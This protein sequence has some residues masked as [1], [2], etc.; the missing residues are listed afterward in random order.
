MKVLHL[1]NSNR[2]SGA[3][4]VACQIVNMFRTDQNIEMIYVS[5]DGEIREALRE[6]NVRYVPISKMTIKEV[7]RVIKVEKP[8][9]VYA[10]DMR[11][12]VIAAFS[13]GNIKL[14]SH[15][16]NNAFDSRKMSVKSLAYLVAARKVDHIFWVSEEAFRDYK[17]CEKL[18]SKS[19]VLCNIIDIGQLRNRMSLDQ[20]CYDNDIVY[21]GRLAYPKNPHRL[22]RVINDVISILPETRVTI[23]GTGEL[24][25]EVKVLVKAYNLE[26]NVKFVGFMANPLKI[27]HDSKVMLMTS[28]WEGTPMCALE[29]MALGVPIVSTPTDGLNKLIDHGVTGFVS[30]DDK[31]LVDYLVA[32]ISHKELRKSL[33]D[34][35]LEAAIGVNDMVR[36]K[37]E[38]QRALF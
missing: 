7:K 31:K 33:S 28:R 9:V 15:I 25:E 34:N 21:V 23:V 3:E 10:H 27:M 26:N 36:Y 14:I 24:E 2:F 19:S 22:I 32:L 30:D 17:F 16:H 35:S 4:N 11:A 5:P 20:S 29:A 8:D 1:L 37:R 13:C 6:R 18:G 12:S 38:I